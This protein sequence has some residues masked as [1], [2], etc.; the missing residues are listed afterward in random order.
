MVRDEGAASECGQPESVEAE[1]LA[2][3]WLAAGILPYWSEPGEKG[4]KPRVRFLLGKELDVKNSTYFWSDFGGRFEQGDQSAEETAA[5]EFAEETL[6][7]LGGDGMD[8]KSRVEQSAAAVRERLLEEDPASTIVTIRGQRYTMFMLQLRQRPDPL[9][10]QIARDE[11]DRVT[12]EKPSGEKRDFIIMD[13]DRLL[14]CSYASH[15]LP[16]DD[17]GDEIKLLPGFARNLRLCLAQA[18]KLI[19]SSVLE[20]SCIVR[21][22]VIIP[23]ESS[24]CLHLSKLVPENMDELRKAL[25]QFGELESMLPCSGHSYGFVT[26]THPQD[27][28]S[29]L[30]KWSVLGV[31]GVHVQFARRE[32]PIGKGAWSSERA[33]LSLIHI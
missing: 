7:I 32:T 8:L 9:M 24:R 15:A 12:L 26:F 10:L 23:A 20:E 18:L 11:N 30:R 5:R 3:S 21:R 27:A 4:E 31:A 22:H 29:A 25:L 14:H 6:G 17:Y 13:A 2:R 33:S 19:R 28:A 16:R 1:G